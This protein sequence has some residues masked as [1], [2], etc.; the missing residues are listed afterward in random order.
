[1]G[2]DELPLD[3]GWR[4]KCWKERYRTDQV[5]VFEYAAEKWLRPGDLERKK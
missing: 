1:L 2:C 5:A 3:D 4:S